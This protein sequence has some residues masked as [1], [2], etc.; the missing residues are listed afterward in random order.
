MRV[1][2]QNKQKKE[3]SHSSP[4]TVNTAS[5]NEQTTVYKISELQGEQGNV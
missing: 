4:V 2:V 3:T 5:T 1:L